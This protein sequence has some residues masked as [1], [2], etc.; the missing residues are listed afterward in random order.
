MDDHG[1]VWIGHPFDSACLTR[2][3]ADSIRSNSTSQNRSLGPAVA[4]RRLR[5]RKRPKPSEAEGI[6]RRLFG[7]MQVSGLLGYKML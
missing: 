4:L 7:V 5:G 6:R 2:A 1:W 3:A